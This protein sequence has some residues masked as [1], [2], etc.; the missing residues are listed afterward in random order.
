MCIT[1]LGMKEY[2]E[3]YQGYLN[4]FVDLDND[5]LQLALQE[6]LTY[7]QEH[8]S[9]LQSP[10]GIGLDKSGGLVALAIRNNI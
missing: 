8:H 7:N 6:S 1:T 9:T 2:E 10:Q 4:D 3:S 5:Q